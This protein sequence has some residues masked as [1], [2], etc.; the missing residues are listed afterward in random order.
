[1][2]KQNKATTLYYITSRTN[3][4][5]YPLVTASICPTAR[6]R[7]LY[8]EGLRV[9]T[10]DRP[11]FRLEDYFLFFLKYA[12]FRYNVLIIPTSAL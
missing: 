12:S 3:S 2:T 11:P 5:L 7:L 4:V 6:H 8:T 10:I 9:Q 1:M